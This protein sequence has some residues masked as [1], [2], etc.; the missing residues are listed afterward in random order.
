MDPPLDRQERPS[1]RW[2]GPAARP[3]GRA[4]SHAKLAKKT[5][6]SAALAAL[7]AG[8]GAVGVD[9][10]DRLREQ[11][12]ESLPLRAGQGCEDLVVDLVQ[13]AVELCEHLLTLR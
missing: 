1:D 2:R 11:D 9:V 7:V 5:A 12:V 8:L 4:Y 10:L 13:G 6:L 3:R